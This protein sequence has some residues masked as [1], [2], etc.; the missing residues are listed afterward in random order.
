MARTHL[1]T[2][3]SS[4][5]AA[6]VGTQHAATRARSAAHSSAAPGGRST[7]AQELSEA[8][9][10]QSARLLGPGLSIAL[11]PYHQGRALS[12]H[13]FIHHAAMA[14]VWAFQTRPLASDK[15][16][17]LIPAGSQQSTAHTAGQ[18]TISRGL[19][20]GPH[21]G[22]GFWL[23]K[24]GF[25]FDFDCRPLSSRGRPWQTASSPAV[26]TPLLIAR[27]VAIHSH[28]AGRGS[29]EHYPTYEAAH[30]LCF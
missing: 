18:S 12:S 17:R 30:S 9:S 1:A 15:L 7:R 2:A 14:P 27:A 28:P 22:F 26:T 25:A 5:L 20:P 8:K 16:M 24:V 29:S 13:S 3:R 23:F 6:R 11:I 4:Q 10:P 21:P 19:V